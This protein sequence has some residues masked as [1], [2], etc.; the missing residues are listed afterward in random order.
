M[1]TES[2]PKIIQ[3]HPDSRMTPQ[4]GFQ[5][6]SDAEEAAIGAVL[7]NPEVVHALMVFL[8]AE[9]FYI[10]RHIYIW[11]AI[12][13]L[14]QKNSQ[15]DYLIL[16]EELRNT[17]RLAEVGG[18]AYLNQLI[19]NTPTSMHGEIYGRIVERCAIR[20]R[21]LNAADE[22][23]ALA[24]NE[25]LALEK[26]REASELI[27]SKVWDNMISAN[28]M[29]WSDL[30]SRNFA[31]V[32]ERIDAPEM[33]DMGIP[34]GLRDLDLITGG[35]QPADLIVLAGRPGSGKSS[36]ALKFILSAALMGAIVHLYT[37]E[38]SADQFISRAMSMESGI[39]LQHLRLGKID[40]NQWSRYVQSVARL[41]NLNILIDDEL[42][43]IEQI[44]S[45]SINWQRRLGCDLVVID[46]GQL[47]SASGEEI[48]GER[49]RRFSNETE[50]QSYIS[51]KCK[52]LA[53]ALNRPVIVLAQ[54]NR[55]VEKRQDKH[56]QLSD[57]RSSGSWEQD[58][59]VVIF[60]YRD[61]MY[62]E[63]TEF[64]NRADFIIAKHRNGPTGGA[65]FHFD[66]TLTKFSDART[67]TIDLSG[68]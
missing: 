10:L 11:E 46:Y 39:N 1:M 16:Q 62:N 2:S 25:E 12:V 51:R 63:A 65:S 52:K 22:I 57:L 44:S 43:S 18:P 32:E 58:A 7:V 42:T 27:H 4:Q 66:K 31:E 59:D 21:L 56:P 24:M 6:L 67:Q 17:G 37:L 13:R 33:Y 64:P 47:L 61:V 36:A 35:W 45:N 38:M 60:I 14:V 28:H 54:L 15:I 48:P 3:A 20:R 49:G 30:V 34:S 19:N 5:V 53:K 9:D 41:G 40:G 8:K 23:K 50:E 68:L 55:E 29:P 26:V